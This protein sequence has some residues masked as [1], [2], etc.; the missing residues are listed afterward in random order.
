MYVCM[1]QLQQTEEPY[2]Q[3]YKYYNIQ[4]L[5]RLK[6]NTILFDTHNEDE[7]PENFQ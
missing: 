2:Q 1:Q 7:P 3:P 6:T 4:S 5:W